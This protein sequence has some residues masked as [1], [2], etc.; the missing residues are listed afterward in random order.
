SLVF[1]IAETI[2]NI[3]YMAGYVDDDASGARR[4]DLVW[5][6]PFQEHIPSP[7]ARLLSLYDDLGIPYERRKQL[8]GPC[9]P[10]IGFSVDIDR[11][12]FTLPEDCKANLIAT[13][14]KFITCTPGHRRRSIH[15]FQALAGHINWALNVF[16]LLRPCLAHIYH[17]LSNKSDP[18]TKAYINSGITRDLE[19][20]LRR[21]DT[22]PRVRIFAAAAWT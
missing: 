9:L 10:Y 22:L 4:D 16:P 18:H 1:W 21:I 19:W 7:L 2:Y 17:K 14:Q 6:A 11:F 15:E 12:S 5:F 8:W 13:I 20:F 3:L